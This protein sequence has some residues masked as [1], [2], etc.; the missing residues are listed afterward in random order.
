MDFVRSIQIASR[1]I[2][3]SN[4]SS[5]ATLITVP[6]SWPIPCA[7][8][9][10]KSACRSCRRGYYVLVKAGPST[11]SVLHIGRDIARDICRRLRAADRSF[12]LCP[13]RA[14]KRAPLLQGSRP[15][16]GWPAAVDSMVWQ[17]AVTR[18]KSML[19]RRF[20]NCMAFSSE[21]GVTSR[22]EDDAR[23]DRLFR[24]RLFEISN[25]SAR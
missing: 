15:E 23:I 7:R 5:K 11:G 12:G 21:A 14:F 20:C 16:A 8:A 4:S 25:P 9:P 18:F 1:Q 10:W 13:S 19:Y 22:S 17:V 3:I 2:Q 6:H 24:P